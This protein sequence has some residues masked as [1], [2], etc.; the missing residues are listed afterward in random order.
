MESKKIV[1]ICGNPD[2]DTFTGLILDTYQAAAEEAW[3]E[4]I[5]YN[6]GELDFDPI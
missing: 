4:V 3:H 2:T 1:I 5:R 6:L